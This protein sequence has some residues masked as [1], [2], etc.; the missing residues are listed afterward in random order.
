MLYI[1]FHLGRQAVNTLTTPIAEVAL[2]ISTRKT[3]RV[4]VK[5][6]TTSTCWV[7]SVSR[8]RSSRR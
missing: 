3:N 1:V 7:I 5:F 2:D 8:V 4:F 6:R